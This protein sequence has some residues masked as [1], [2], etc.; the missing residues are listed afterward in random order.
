MLCQVLYSCV[1]LLGAFICC[2]VSATGLVQGPLCL[3]NSTSGQT[4][5]V[6]LQAIPERWE[7]HRWTVLLMSVSLLTLCLCVYSRWI[8]L[9]NRTVWSGVCLEPQNVVQWNMVLFGVMGT[10]SGLQT[11]LCAVNILNSLLGMVLGHGLC[12]T[13]VCVSVF[14]VYEDQG[15]VLTWGHLDLLRSSHFNWLTVCMFQVSPGLVWDGSTWI[16][17][18]NMSLRDGRL[19]SFIFVLWE[20]SFKVWDFHITQ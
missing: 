20:S 13:K 15:G 4:W 11:V 5:G 9:Y 7:P 19:K 3:F 10:V 1:S 14:C 17:N 8:Y 18:E 16:L 12:R 6:P 2:F